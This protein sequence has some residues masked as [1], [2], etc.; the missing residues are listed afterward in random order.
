MFR[1][2]IKSLVLLSVGLRKMFIAKFDMRN[3]LV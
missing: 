1:L 2:G 3:I